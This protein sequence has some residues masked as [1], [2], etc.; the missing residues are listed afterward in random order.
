MLGMSV[1]VFVKCTVRTSQHGSKFRGQCPNDV[2]TYSRCDEGEGG[3]YH[4]E[5]GREEV[6]RGSVKRYHA[7]NLQESYTL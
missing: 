3:R 1:Y 2:V 5:G 6:Q 4:A 7:D